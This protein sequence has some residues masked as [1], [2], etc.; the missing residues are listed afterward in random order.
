MKLKEKKM[1]D[2]FDQQLYHEAEQAALPDFEPD[3]K[4]DICDKLFYELRLCVGCKQVL[5]CEN[6]MYQDPDSLDWYCDPECMPERNK[7]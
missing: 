4:C 3:Q 1:P 6:C 7:E 2:G 5:G